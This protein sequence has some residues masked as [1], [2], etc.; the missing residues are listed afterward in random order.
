MTNPIDDLS[1][2]HPI[3]GSAIGVFLRN[4]LLVFLGVLFVIGLGLV[5]CPF[6]WSLGPS[7]GID[8]VPVDAIPDLGE[9]QQIVFTEWPGRSPEDVEEQVTYPLT[10]ALLGQ[11]GV[12]SVRSTSMFGFSTIYVIFD[13]S[14]GF[15]DSRTRLL[16][17]L[18]SLREGMDYPEGTQPRLGPDATGLGQVFWYTLEGRDE[19]GHATG[20][21]DLQ[22]LRSIQ[23]WQVRQSLQAVQGVSE[24]ASV[25]GHV[26]EYQVDIDPDAMRHYEVTL[27]DIY[28][29]VRDSNIDVSAG[30]V[31]IS[32][33][34]YFVRGIGFIKRVEDLRQA[35]V[36]V[37]DNVPILLDQVASVSLGP[38]QRR[39]ALDK[40]GA[41]AVGGV[42]V[43]R[44]GSN[45]LK[46]IDAVNKQIESVS[47]G[48]P[49]KVIV[50]FD[51]VE[52]SD[53]RQFAET[54]GFEGY[55]NGDLN[56]EA[57]LAHLD[58]LPADQRPAWITVSQVA[59]VP[60]YDRTGL[61]LETLGTLENALRGEIIITFIVVVLMVMHLRSSVLIG[62]MLPLAVGMTFIA[63]KLFGVD[64]NIVAL[65]G[66]AIAVGTIVDMG[67][68]LCEN[69]LR[70]LDESAGGESRMA[71]VQRAAGEVAGAVLAAVMTTI[72]GFL[73]VFT[74]TGRAGKLFRPLAFTKTFALLASV[75][76]A[77][78][79]IPP[80]AYLLFRPR[81][82][83]ADRSRRFHR[84]ARITL[85]ALTVAT[86]G[87][88]LTLSWEPL[89][90]MR[91]FL[92]NLV[93]VVVLIGALVT[94]FR[95]F[96]WKYPVILGWCLAHKKTFLAIPLILLL[97][98]GLTWVGFDGVFSPAPK[99]L[100]IYGPAH[101]SNLWALGTRAFPGL[102][103]EFMPSLDEGSFLWMPS[104]SVHG[105]ITEALDIVSK[106]DRAIRAIP[107]VDMV[108]G[109]IGRVDS[110]LDPAPLSMIETV[111]TYKPEYAQQDGQW[112]RQWRDHIHDPDDIW[113]EIQRA[114]KVPGANIASKLQPI[115]TRLLML[116]SGITAK[117]AVKVF[118][119]SLEAIEAA[120]DQ[121]GKS[122]GDLPGVRRETINV[123]RVVG[124]PYLVVD[125]TA[126]QARAAMKRHG[127]N[128]RNVLDIVQGAIGGQRITTTVEGRERYAVRVRYQR[129]LR[130]DIEQMERILIDTPTGERVPLVELASFQYVRGP[131]AIKSENTFKLGYVTFDI[132]PDRAEVDVAKEVRHHLDAMRASGRLRL[133]AGITYELTGSFENELA[134]NRR[135]R[136]IVPVAL[137][138]I[139]VILYL[140]FRTVSTTIFIFLG[141]FVAFSG[142]FLLLWLY[143]QSWFLNV[144]ILGMSMR[145]LFQVH[146]INLSTAIW[147]GFLALFGIAT[148][149]GVVMGTY[150][151]Q[152]FRKRSPGT[153]KDIREAVVYAGTR[154]ARACLMTTATTILALLPVMTSQGRGSDIMVP[155]ALPSFGGM[156]IE[157][158][159][160]LVVPVLY[161]M[162]RERR[163]R[164]QT[165]LPSNDPLQ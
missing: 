24:V 88:V 116:Q 106:Q 65:S 28:R 154:R 54:N 9:N 102:G 110:P 125:M 72:V 76:V 138:L 111:V 147:V 36:K 60:F 121:I 130:D 161:C 85:Y 152:T 135:L 118:G 53:V 149:D 74:L 124:K 114:G 1:P 156:G 29:T 64:A 58:R 31:E 38:A 115:E 4:K 81:K 80:A 123:D 67:I 55:A 70:H 49:R 91:G 129:E 103:R 160:M 34:E 12:Q 165:S 45:P 144:E 84:I 23:D 99:A 83:D 133:P 40:D 96:Q 2:D 33:V 139:F 46:V 151:E 95:L 128:P 162:A 8:P 131:Q 159:T 134:A 141:V 25:G 86:A 101:Q 18:N 56:H 150:L 41:E 79:V 43:A 127:L 157:V 155:M 98:A 97:F 68:V 104:L 59:I 126:R 37:V 15:F 107:E 105:S 57:W 10:T 13:G 142:G 47:P 163:L 48:L 120:G 146:G 63:M 143:G 5:F 73:P 145:Q 119:P 16:E 27:Q 66:I 7:L 122:L 132:A 164:K 71:V 112:V 137:A 3:L 20:G 136:V 26:R 21:W 22:E 82:K 51:Q 14:I 17:R 52:P 62:G 61:I 89:G 92:R 117:M 6:D 158:L 153:V 75:M 93:F 94:V 35:V 109:K 90:P 30:T 108:V 50:D 69:I 78:I 42:V 77:L 19:A 113:D 148:D 87:I 140:Q 44:F 11:K 32:R 39:G 100:G